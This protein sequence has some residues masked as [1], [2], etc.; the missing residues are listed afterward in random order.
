[1]HSVLADCC[2]RYI[3]TGIIAICMLQYDRQAH[4]DR[5]CQARLMSS[6]CTLPM[7]FCKDSKECP[8]HVL[9]QD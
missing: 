7:I 6:A 3:M 8:G 9:L 1:M 5:D 2:T 4:T